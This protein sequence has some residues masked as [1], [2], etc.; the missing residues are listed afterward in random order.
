MSC[1]GERSDDVN[2]HRR[3][4]LDQVSLAQLGL[5]FKVKLKLLAC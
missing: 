3:P 5:L 2:E 4:H 1:I